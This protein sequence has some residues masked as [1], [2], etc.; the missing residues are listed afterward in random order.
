[1]FLINSGVLQTRIIVNKFELFWITLGSI[2][3]A[4]LRAR[5]VL[6]YAT[7]YFRKPMYFA[8]TSLGSIV[9]CD[10]TALRA[11]LIFIEASKDSHRTMFLFLTSLGS[12]VTA[13]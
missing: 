8:R 7:Q 6:N 9:T 5:W 2:A 4:E 10:S 3:N 13:S 11:N 1:M 12:T